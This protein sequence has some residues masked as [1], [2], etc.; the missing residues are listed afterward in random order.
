[1][2]QSSATFDGRSPVL[3]LRDLLP[4]VD[5]ASERAGRTLQ[6]VAEIKHAS[7]FASIGLP[8]DELFAAEI[9]GWASRDRLIVEAF[10]QTV[11]ARHPAIAASPARYVY[12]ARV[13][14]LAG[15]SRR[16][17]R[18]RRRRTYAAHLTR[19]RTRATRPREVDGISVDKKLLLA[20]DATG[21]VTGTTDLV[22]RAHAVGLTVYTWTLRAENRFLAEGFRRGSSPRDFGHWRGEFDV[23][24][25]PAST[26]S[27]PT[28]P[29][30]C[31]RALGDSSA[32]RRLGR[33]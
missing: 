13:L 4:I 7:Y 14:R 18:R 22:S 8:L 24:L 16:P 21:R 2:R 28:S 10:E 33:S 1:M 26:A 20:T 23:I 5:A 11:L 30:S 32:E 31:S 6:L 29:T 27:S 9:A 12:L 15:R 17:A 3:R 25:A 19:R